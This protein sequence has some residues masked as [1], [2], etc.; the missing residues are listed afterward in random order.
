MKIKIENHYRGYDTRLEA[1]NWRY[2]ASV[3]GL[4]QYF[5]F[6]KRIYGK[7]FYIE[8]D[9][10]ILYSS[11]DI[12]EERYV[13]FTEYY[14]SEDMNHKV[15]EEWL[16]KEEFNDEDIKRINERLVGG[17]ANTV[18][19]KVI[20]K[21]RFDGR[22]KYRILELIENN[23]S[24]LVKET[25][26]YKNNL[27]KNYAN[28]KL[29]LEFEEQLHCRLIG[30]NI[31][32]GKKS[33]SISYQFNT[34]TFVK[35][36]CIEFDF[37]PFAF[38]N[39]QD[40]LFINNNYAIK[41]LWQ[42]F[43]QLENIIKNQLELEK[44]NAKAVLFNAIIE[45]SDFI[46]FDVE[47]IVK[48][49]DRKFFETLYIRKDAIQILKSLKDK[50]V[51][52]FS[53]KQGK[54]NYIHIQTEVVNY[55]LN[56]T[57]LDDLIEMFLKDENGNWNYVINQL[58][59]VNLKIKGGNDMT[60]DMKSAFGC[61]KEVV[62]KFIERKQENKIDTYRQKLISAIVFHDYDRV[63]NILLQL[64]N[65]AEVSFGFAYPLFENFEANKEL[66]YTFIN[67]LEKKQEKI[68]GKRM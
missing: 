17:I 50:R 18:M 11:E 23:R 25:Y 33:K 63:C 48:N 57:L 67:A 24:L 6:L 38:T 46:N 21:E 20:G 30:Y 5:N 4:M 64:S 2:S 37:I 66:A 36:D 8:D 3:V 27:Y 32:E 34:E 53:Y 65:Y 22:N 47:V 39:T 62:K 29:L 51:F 41:Q 54:N 40:A 19:K 1:S 59:D 15:V 16:S 55:I 26:R 44:G 43:G 31:D 52:S 58:I 60:Q 49:R 28:T 35:A 45:S 9:D 13:E 56:N 42:T 12:N 61:A 68:E 7:D 10:A 14:F